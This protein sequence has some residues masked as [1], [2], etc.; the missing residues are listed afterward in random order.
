MTGGR[1][2]RRL[3]SGGS[4]APSVEKL[5]ETEREGEA[6][7][8]RT[9]REGDAPAAGILAGDAVAE[10]RRRERGGDLVRERELDV[11][12]RRPPLPFL[13]D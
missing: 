10:L 8:E 7:K 1:R 2:Q 9:K 5:R 6:G 12:E 11:G 3:L 4:R 13:F